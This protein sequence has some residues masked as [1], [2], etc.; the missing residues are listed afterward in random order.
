MTHW[1]QSSQDILY[2]LIRLRRLTAVCVAL[3]ILAAVAAGI[4]FG[5]SPDPTMLAVWIVV[6]ILHSVF[7]PAGWID[8]LA[9]ALTMALCYL[10]YP[11][12]FGW[13]DASAQQIGAAILLIPPVTFIFLMLAISLSHGRIAMGEIHRKDRMN[14]PL[15]AE[16]VAARLFHEAGAD[17]F[18]RFGEADQN[19][20]IPVWVD[21]VF[22]DPDKGF[23]LPS[24]QDLQDRAPDYFIRMLDEG[25]LHRIEQTVVPGRAR[26]GAPLTSVCE[27][28][29]ISTAP[30]TCQ[31]VEDEVH[32]LW[33]MLTYVSGWLT[34]HNADHFHDLLG[35]MTGSTT[36][37]LK[38]L[39]QVTLMS[40]I[41]QAMASGELAPPN[42]TSS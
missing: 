40:M 36:P 17:D 7:F 4:I 29:V 18:R 21:F 8:A 10:L 20:L 15:P 26:D 32:N 38:T 41:A 6:L 27:T 19:G 28:R 23:V 13:T 42:G 2:R 9:L 14:I 25:P 37:A 30:D 5:I 16:A 11:L 33:D 12:V 3:V 22:P 34:D 24:E 1:P 39:P 31:V 35:D